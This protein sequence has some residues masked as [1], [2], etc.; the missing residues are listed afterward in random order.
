[1]KF[2]RIVCI[3]LITS[4]SYYPLIHLAIANSSSLWSEYQDE[5]E[6]DYLKK[7]IVFD[8]FNP[9]GESR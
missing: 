1:M 9:E 4:Y 6:Y 2:L 5:Y 3:I 7:S 8:I